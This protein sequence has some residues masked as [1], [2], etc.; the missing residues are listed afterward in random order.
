M[1]D[2]TILDACTSYFGV[3]QVCLVQEVAE[4]YMKNLNIESLQVN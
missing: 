4:T 3:S 1:A 2:S